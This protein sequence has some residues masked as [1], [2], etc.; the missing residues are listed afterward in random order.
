MSSLIMVMVKSY[1][2]MFQNRREPL[3][4]ILGYNQHIETEIRKCHERFD[5]EDDG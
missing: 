3:L 2:V 1:F 5:F 4:Q